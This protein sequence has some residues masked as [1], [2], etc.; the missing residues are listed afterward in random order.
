MFIAIYCYYTTRLCLFHFEKV[1]LIESEAR[2]VQTRKIC[3]W[4]FEEDKLICKYFERK[5][6][7]DLSNVNKV[8]SFLV[9]AFYLNFDKKVN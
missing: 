9:K 7:I 8:K 1:L 2:R 4:I 3:D 6:F 5:F